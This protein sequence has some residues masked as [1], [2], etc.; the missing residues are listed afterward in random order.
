MDL[1]S[2]P[3]H[4]IVGAA[5]LLLSAAA[6]DRADRRE[7]GLYLQLYHSLCL[8]LDTLTRSQADLEG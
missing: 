5:S 3:G 6:V 8:A 4:M 2:R 7:G 1:L